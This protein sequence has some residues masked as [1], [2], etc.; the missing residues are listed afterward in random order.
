MRYLKGT[1]YFSLD[2]AWDNYEVDADSVHDTTYRRS[3]T[4]YVFTF[5][6]SIISYNNVKHKII[7]LCSTEAEYMSLSEGA[8]Q[9]IYLR[10]FLFELIGSLNRIYIYNDNQ[11]TLKSIIIVHHKR[12]KHIDVK[13]SFIRELLLMGWLIL[14]IYRLTRRLLIFSQRV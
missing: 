13:H 12:Y 3:Y 11:S 2:F 10:N 8:K 1:K 5:C 7:T 4:G 9:A 6:G 14:H